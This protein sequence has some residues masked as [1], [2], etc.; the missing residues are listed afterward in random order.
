M[1]VKKVLSFALALTL[2][3]GAFQTFV[4]NV[5]NSYAEGE[6]AE[7]IFTFMNCVQFNKKTGTLRIFG[8]V[9]KEAVQHFNNEYADINPLYKKK[10]VKSIIASPG[11]VLPEDS[12]FL[13]A[14]FTEVTSMNLNAADTSKVT[15]MTNMFYDNTNLET[16]DISNFDTSNVKSMARMFYHCPKLKTLDLSSFDTSNVIDMS[17]MFLRDSSLTDIDFSS[18]NTSKVTDMNGMFFGCENIAFLGLAGFDTYNVI[19]MS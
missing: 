2:S 14:Y 10:G 7:D 5:P 19:N 8:E 4:R 13:F 3:F 12:S 1:R 16:L 15:D 6:T 9:D 17:G 18:F 11:A